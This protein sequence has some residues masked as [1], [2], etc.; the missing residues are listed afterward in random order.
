MCAIKFHIPF[1][2]LSV[3]Y[4]TY[5]DV[6]GSSILAH[7]RGSV[8]QSLMTLPLSARKGLTNLSWLSM[9]F[10]NLLSVLLWQVAW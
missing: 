1:D 7:S 6:P 5:M 8:G 2:N 4:E 3:K 10:L 9:D